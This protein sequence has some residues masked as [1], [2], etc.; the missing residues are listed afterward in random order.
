MNVRL[1]MISSTLALTLIAT[2]AAT[3]PGLAKRT[4][5]APAAPVPSMAPCPSP[6]PLVAPDVASAENPT[7]RV[8]QGQVFVLSLGAAPGTGYHWID[9]RNPGDRPFGVIGQT[10]RPNQTAGQPPVVGGA[11]EQ[12]WLFR[13]TT[14][15][16]GRI[17]LRY[18]PPT[19]KIYAGEAT[20]DLTVTVDPY[21]AVC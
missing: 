3:A 17:E 2:V 14:P 5:A 13:A 15:G 16:T 8:L 6:P 21:T 9:T 11:G 19:E 12:L 1:R 10:F 7:L 4:A 20:V 18:V